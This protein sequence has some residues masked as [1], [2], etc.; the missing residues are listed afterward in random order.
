M[1][2]ASRNILTVKWLGVPLLVA[3][4]FLVACNGTALVTLTATSQQNTFLAYR[5]GLVSVRLQTASGGSSLTV[6]PAATMVDFTQ[7][8][9]VSEIIGAAAV[10]KGTYTSVVLTLDYS[11]AQIVYDDGSL[12]GIT[13][14]PLNS[15]GAALAQTSLTLTLDPANDFKITTKSTAR[16]ALDF[17]LTASNIVD[18]AQKT[19]TVTPIVA[20]SAL[21]I[22]SK[23]IRVRGPLLS[24]GSTDVSFSMGITPFEST[25]AGA[26]SVVITPSDATTYE[27]SGAASTGSAALSQ[28]SGLG[29]SKLVVA[30]GTLSSV[31]LTDD[32]G[33]TTTNADGVTVDQ[34]TTSNDV[35]FLAT[36][37]LAGSS[38]QGLGFDLISGT[39][40][41][42]SGNT[43]TV[44]DATAV[45][46]DGTNT[47]IG[48]PTTITIGADTLVTLFGQGTA[49]VNSPLQISVG[50]QIDAFGTLTATSASSATLDATAGH[51]RLDNTD[52]A[53]LVT[54]VEDGAVQIDLDSIGGR[55]ISAL[56][57]S[58]SGSNPAQYLVTT[59][60]LDLT[61]AATGVPIIAAGT[62]NAFGSTTPGFTASSLL[63][64]TTIQAQI[65]IDWGAGTPTPFVT[66]DSSAIDL[67]IKNASIGT[68]HQISVGAQVDNLLQSTSDPL[69][70][71]NTTA[72][73]VVFLIAHAV[74]GTIENFNTYAAFITQLQTELNGTVLATSFS[75]DGQYT[76]STFTFAATAI[77]VLLNN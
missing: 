66:F 7:L 65:L 6:L 64:P 59:G 11:A 55:S 60:S 73:G 46:N 76:D 72:T 38:V 63:D 75:A 51:V 15:S 34:S 70:E 18:T 52:A 31:S 20:A 22:D 37:V 23:V 61:N 69:I 21:P 16:L 62:P 56:D 43:L 9:D 68:V 57:F 49:D 29:G 36:Q 77:T 28:L 53:G 24:V 26:G 74:S 13:L 54:E 47:F 50:S 40:A 25:V 33:D 39:V 32:T 10:K 48:G 1:T 8:T 19:V 17:K 4:L 3:S 41:A 35:Q 30:Y 71:P 42:R 58:G 44:E 2:K 12:D 67:D 27:V 45:A 14:S 5:V